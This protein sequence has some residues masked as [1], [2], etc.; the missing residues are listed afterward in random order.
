MPF[1]HCL[2]PFM[3]QFMSQFM[4]YSP[5][6]NTFCSTM[7]K[8]CYSR[9]YQTRE[10]TLQRNFFKCHFLKLWTD[11]RNTRNLGRQE[12]KVLSLLKELNT[13]ISRY[14][15]HMS[16]AD[17]ARFCHKPLDVGSQRIPLA[18]GEILFE[19][20]PSPIAADRRKNRKRRRT[21]PASKMRTQGTQTDITITQSG[22][23]SSVPP[24]YTAWKIES[25]KSR[26]IF[27]LHACVR[28]IEKIVSIVSWVFEDIPIMSSVYEGMIHL[29]ILDENVV[30]EICQNN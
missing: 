1:C 25:C 28:L 14:S 6:C 23:M 7:C 11:L 29:F 12:Q 3:P 20:Q 22:V 24:T 21:N 9:I 8:T 27:H 2:Y 5:F 13:R 10:K 26:A 15:A 30:P 18:K 4:L 17:F 19:I 16:K